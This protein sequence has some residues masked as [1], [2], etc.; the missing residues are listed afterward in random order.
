[1]NYQLF[2]SKKTFSNKF[3]ISKIDFEFLLNEFHF[4]LNTQTHIEESS[5][6]PNVFVL[7]FKTKKLR[8]EVAFQ[9]VNFLFA[10]NNNN[11]LSSIIKLA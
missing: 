3:E 11:K 2:T 7:S 5:I 4:F 9:S 10:K 6:H 8:N 1:M